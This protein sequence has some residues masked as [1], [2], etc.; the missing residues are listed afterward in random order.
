MF[1][2]QQVRVKAL[3]GLDQQAFIRKIREYLLQLEKEIEESDHASVMSEA[4]LQVQQDERQALEQKTESLKR[5]IEEQEQKA[6]EAKKQ[7]DLLVDQQ[8]LLLDFQGLLA[9]FFQ[10][11]FFTQ[12]FSDFALAKDMGEMTLQKMLDQSTDGL[13]ITVKGENY[14]YVK[15]PDGEYYFHEEAVKNPKF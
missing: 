10:P 5:K 8:N 15:A 6:M 13:S 12:R 3:L 4:D 2:D 7:H 9:G 1:D 11:R 14:W